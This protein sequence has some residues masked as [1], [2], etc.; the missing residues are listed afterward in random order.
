MRVDPD[1]LALE[2]SWHER[3]EYVDGCTEIRLTSLCPTRSG[4]VFLL[5]LVAWPMKKSDTRIPS[6]HLSSYPTDG[7][8]SLCLAQKQGPYRNTV[9][10]NTQERQRLSELTKI[11]IASCLLANLINAT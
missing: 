8:R 2:K 6:Q 4:L 7:I 9:I 10:F 3:V 11:F 5:S 1:H